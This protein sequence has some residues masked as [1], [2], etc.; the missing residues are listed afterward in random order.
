MNKSAILSMLAILLAISLVIGFDVCWYYYTT[1]TLK[2]YGVPD[3]DIIKRLDTFYVVLGFE[4][5]IATISIL[6][7]LPLIPSNSSDSSDS[8]WPF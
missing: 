1:D 7:S 3:S 8:A 5:F 4:M 6:V 2:T